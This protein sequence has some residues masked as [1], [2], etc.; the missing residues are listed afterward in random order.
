MRNKITQGGL[1]AAF[2]LALMALGAA[3][4]S[5][6]HFT[7]LSKLHTAQGVSQ[8]VF[9]NLSLGRNVP[10]RPI[11]PNHVRQLAA[12]LFYDSSRGGVGTHGVFLG[13]VVDDLEPHDSTGF[14]STELDTALGTPVNDRVYVEVIWVP[15]SK[16]TVG[17][18]KTRVADGLGGFIETGFSEG[19]VKDLG[20][21]DSFTLPKDSI[22][23]GQRQDAI[24]CVC[25]GQ[26]ALGIVATRFEDFGI[27]GCP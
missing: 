14:S 19:D 8:Y 11:N 18:T 24:D 26:T 22:V 3:P 2:V 21:P 5:A 6:D 12:L 1:A 20:H 9:S 17:S 13:C 7:K 23:T 4:A 15:K 10:V 16:V 25:A 27:T